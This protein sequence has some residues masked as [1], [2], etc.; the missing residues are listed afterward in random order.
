MG[1][2]ADLGNLSEELRAAGAPGSER[3]N[4]VALEV[5]VNATGARPNIGTEKRELFSEDTHTVL[6]FP[7]GAV[8]SLNAAVVPG[9]LI[10]LTNKEKNQEVVCQVIRKRN[11]RPTSCYVELQF[12]EPQADF[13]DV[14]FPEKSAT[15][16]ELLATPVEQSVVSAEV[17]EEPAAP[18]AEQPNPEE[19]ELL[20]QEVDALREQ[21]K[22]LT[23]AKKREEEAARKAVEEAAKKAEE[24]EAAAK[25]EAAAKPL[26]RMNLPAAPAGPERSGS[27]REELVPVG[28]PTAPNQSMPSAAANP[29]AKIEKSKHSEER[30][31]FEDLLPQPELDF[32]HAPVP[33]KRPPEDDDPYSIYKPLRKK[34]GIKEVVLTI[35]ATLALVAGLATAWY[36]DLL[37]MARRKASTQAASIT[38]KAP[39]AKPAA[40]ANAQAKGTGDATA[41]A[42]TLSNPASGGATGA[43]GEITVAAEGAAPTSLDA[44]GGQDNN[45]AGLGSE[46][47]DAR[48][49]AKMDSPAPGVPTKDVSP[50]KAKRSGAVAGTTRKRGAAAPTVPEPEPVAPDAPLVAAKL[51]RAAAPVYPPDAMRNFITGDVRINAEVGADGH[52][53]KVTVISGPAALRE[54]AVEAMKRYEYDPAT[55]GGKA[56]ASQVTVTIK[57]WFDP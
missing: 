21:L 4:P 22:E 7:D 50:P 46:A 5:R 57:F 14:Q 13:W 25:R 56:V 34:V 30:D 3:A 42:G 29:P 44:Q 20:K 37:P 48:G 31:A 24:E 23:E 17:T 54:A 45:K 55:K 15:V 52:I 49:E 19:V 36:K 11:Y 12:T 39:V 33:V 38:K 26:I 18:Q 32:S 28:A 41:P 53:G 9:Q 35:V 6:V 40:E 1:A 2:T 16:A 47:N 27:T 43:N 51:I 8:I 10:Y